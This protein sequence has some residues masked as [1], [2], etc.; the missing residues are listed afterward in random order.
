VTKTCRTCAQTK[1]VSE[2]YKNKNTS[3]GYLNWCKPCTIAR[4]KTGVTERRNKL[5]AYIQAIKLER[6]CTDCGYNDHPSA[7][8][9]D[10]LPGFVKEHRIA[11]M[12]G[13]PTKA[14]IDAEIAKCEVVCANCH[15]IRTAN[16]LAERDV[17]RQTLAPRGAKR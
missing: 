1:S 10:H 17:A 11:T 6:G 7:L 2:F 15:R 4:Y 12:S 3:D 8:E 16:R 14:K 13:G 9:F 5:L